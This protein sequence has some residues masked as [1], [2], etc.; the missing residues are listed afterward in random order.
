MDNRED[1]SGWTVFAMIVLAMASFTGGYL[2]GDIKGTSTA[3]R[4]WRD[5]CVK[6]GYAYPEVR[7]FKK[8]RW[9]EQDDAE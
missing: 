9:K 1:I 5:E 4:A 3:D 7:T 6:R 2:I 8:W